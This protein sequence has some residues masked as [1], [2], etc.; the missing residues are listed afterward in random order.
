[1]ADEPF[2]YQPFYCEENIWHLTQR[3]AGR[4]SHVVFITNA[5]RRCLLLGQRAGGAS[6]GE[7]VWDYHVVL[8]GQASGAA[9]QV[10]DL[11]CTAGAPLPARRWITATFAHVGHTPPEFDP[12]FRVIDAAIFAERFASD[13]RHMRQS[14]GSWQA[15]PPPWPVIGDGHNLMRWVD[16]DDHEMP[17]EVIDLAELRRRF[18]GSRSTRPPAIQ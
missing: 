17:G 11:D 13:R 7:V 15:P 3:L 8:F 4:P 12:R 14:D 2:S 16:L 9:W 1:M 5:S 10:W 6:A 18:A